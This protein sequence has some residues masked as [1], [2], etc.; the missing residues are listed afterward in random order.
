MKRNRF[1]IILL[2]AAAAAIAMIPAETP[3]TPM[4]PG[5]MP[6]DSLLAVGVPDGVCP[7]IINYEGFTVGFNPEMHQPWF[8]AWE[9][10]PERA[11]ADVSTRADARFAPDPDVAGCATL[12]DYRRSGFDRGHMA[13]AADMKWSH[14]AM[15]DCHLLTNMCPQLQAINSGAWATIEKNAR[16]WTRRHGHLYIVAGPVLS[17]SLTRTIGRS[18]IPVPERF[19]KVIVAPEADPPMGIAFVVPN[20][21]F[22]GG[23]QATVTTIDHVELI[24]GFDFFAALPD[25]LEDALESQASMAAWNH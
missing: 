21:P 18:E 20:H 24:T 22:D 15:A 14:Q 12:N 7:V 6:S 23:A 4:A 9:L 8:V 11:F 2:L 3:A 17:D 25:P 5:Q 19:F 1:L 16:N 13:P 10:T